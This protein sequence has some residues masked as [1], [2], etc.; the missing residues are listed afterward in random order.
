MA[1]RILVAEDDCT[2]AKVL[3]FNL[4]AAGY[5]VTIAS[6]GRQAWMAAQRG[7]FDVL[8][9]DYKMPYL[10]GLDLCQLLRQDRRYAD[11]P[12]ILLSSFCR[13]LDMALVR[14]R[15]YLSA[16]FEKPIA[17]ADLARAIEECLVATA[18]AG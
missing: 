4:V 11:L 16:I 18:C 15:F 17:A 9:T 1:S 8:I 7:R 14:S 5:D 3:R 10:T 6:D 2:Q 13:E 12:I